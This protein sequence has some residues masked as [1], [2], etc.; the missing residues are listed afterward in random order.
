VANKERAYMLSKSKNNVI[1]VDFKP[2]RPNDFR[3]LGL[4]EKTT[5]QIP[6]LCQ[7]KKEHCNANSKI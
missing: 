7:L 3:K 2:K 6:Y 5:N 4:P 1:W